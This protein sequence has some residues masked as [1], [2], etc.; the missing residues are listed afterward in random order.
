MLMV[1]DASDFWTFMG[2]TKKISDH[3]LSVWTNT[4]MILIKIIPSSEKLIEIIIKFFHNSV[5]FR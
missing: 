2:F 3:I 1:H 5:S 4:S